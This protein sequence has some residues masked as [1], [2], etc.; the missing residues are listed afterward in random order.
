MTVHAF[1]V[2]VEE[3]F[4]VSALASVINRE[5]WQSQESRVVANTQRLMALLD[6]ANSKGTFF[7]LGWIAE[8]HPELVRAIES[9]G[10]EVASHGWAHELIF[11]QDPQVFRQQ[12]E[13]SKKLLED[14]SGKPVLGYRA[15]SF[16]IRGDSMWALDALAEC[17]FK[18][19]SSIFPV[20][21]DVYGIPDAAL[22]PGKLPDHDL[23][24]FPMTTAPLLGLK[25]PVSGGG[26]F[27]LFP[28]WLTRTLLRRIQSLERS[29]MFYIHPWEVDPEQPVHAVKGFSK[30]R[31]YNN[32]HQCE[33]RLKRLFQDFEFTTVEASLREMGLLSPA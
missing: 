11:E 9:A 20:R 3:A 24:E 13:R 2:D 21:H 4:Q 7:I 23:I 27:R 29:I 18:Y 25:V 19:D 22:T 30:F 6:D 14:L 26:Y 31:H 28:Y 5:C 32:L 1:S 16:S 33:P 17:G 12:T 15:A 10:H 8:K